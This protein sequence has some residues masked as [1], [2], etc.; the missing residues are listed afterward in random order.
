MV[1]VSNINEARIDLIASL[2]SEYCSGSYAC[3]NCHQDENIVWYG[4]VNINS[5]NINNHYEPIAALSEVLNNVE[6]LVLLDHA[7]VKQ[8]NLTDVNR[9]ETSDKYQMYDLSIA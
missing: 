2:E 8:N 6:V 7:T 3:H 4:Y 5:I 1:D 9:L